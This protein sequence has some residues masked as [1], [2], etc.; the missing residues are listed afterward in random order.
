MVSCHP[1]DVHHHHI[2]ERRVAGEVHHV[3]ENLCGVVKDRESH[4]RDEEADGEGDERVGR[5]EPEP[6]G[7]KPPEDGD[8]DEDV[9][10]RVLGVGDE[11]LALVLLSLPPFIG[12]YGDVDDERRE[13]D[14]DGDGGD[15]GGDGFDEPLI[16]FIKDPGGGQEEHRPDDQGPERLYLAVTIGVLRVGRS[17]CEVEGD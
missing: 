9:A 7:K 16:S 5:R 12:G 1:R 3:G 17:P 8:R 2:D 6:D 15:I 11:D 4:P 14:P 13:H 10:S